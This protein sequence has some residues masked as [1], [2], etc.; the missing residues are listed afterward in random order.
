MSSD[1]FL[2]INLKSL[3]AT[4]AAAGDMAA[5][6]SRVE[7]QVSPLPTPRPGPNTF[8]KNIWLCPTSGSLHV[9]PQLA[10]LLAPLYSHGAL[11]HSPPCPADG[12]R[13]PGLSSGPQTLFGS[14]TSRL[15]L[16]T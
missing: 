4:E 9:S 6:Q 1:L 11:V 13:C 10:L 5:V 7:V 12:C 16:L 2:P 15:R 3:E 14:G 8:H